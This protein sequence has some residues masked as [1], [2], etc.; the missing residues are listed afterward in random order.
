[1]RHAYIAE[2]C[3]VVTYCDL[4]QHAA[5]TIFTTDEIRVRPLTKCVKCK[6]QTAKLGLGDAMCGNNATGVAGYAEKIS[7]SRVKTA[8]K[9]LKWKLNTIRLPAGS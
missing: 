9:L 5:G 1:M 8:H 6:L 4:L 3:K 2:E 7:H